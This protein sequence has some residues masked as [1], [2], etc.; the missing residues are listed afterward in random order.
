MGHLY[1][2][3][4]RHMLLLGQLMHSHPPS[5]LDG[6]ADF[7]NPREQIQVTPDS[8]ALSGLVH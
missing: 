8:A 6:F 2:M 5:S 1:A 4:L 7:R 3:K